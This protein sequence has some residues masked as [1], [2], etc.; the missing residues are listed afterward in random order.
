MLN[1]GEECANEDETI[2]YFN[3]LDSILMSITIRI[4]EQKTESVKELTYTLPII[5]TLF[6]F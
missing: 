3:H 2:D 6:D 1:P 5:A 4:F